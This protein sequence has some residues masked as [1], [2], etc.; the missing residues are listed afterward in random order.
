MVKTKTEPPPPR[1]EELPI[2]RPRMDLFLRF[3][4]RLGRTPGALQSVSEAL[5]VQLSHVV[6][7]SLNRVLLFIRRGH[8]TRRGL[9]VPLLVRQVHVDIQHY[10]G[11]Q[12]DTVP[13]Q[14][15][16][17]GRV[18]SRRLA[19]FEGLFMESVPSFIFAPSIE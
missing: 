9:A 6:H 13:D 8:S 17:V 5:V 12:L 16:N 10:D 4:L 2:D 19:R 15:G 1:N 14:H 11:D 3:P 7:P 18:V